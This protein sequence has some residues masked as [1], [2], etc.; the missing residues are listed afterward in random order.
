MGEVY[1]AADELLGS[2][3]ALKVIRADVETDDPHATERFKREILLARKV[4][5]PNVCRILDVGDH[6]GRLFLTMEYLRGQTLAY[7]L[8]GGQKLSLAEARRLVEQLA[9]GLGAAHDQG[10]VHR[11]F[12][13]ANV[14]LVESTNSL[15]RAVITD[16]GV[17][18]GV[19]LP[20]A[21]LTGK[22]DL[23]GTPAYMAPE[24]LEGSN[25][26]GRA[27]VYALGCVLYEMVTG[28]RPFE[29]ETALQAVIARVKRGPP[30]PR[31][32]APELDRRWEEAILRCLKLE[33]EARFVDIR[34]VPRALDGVRTRNPRAWR[35]RALV[36]LAITFGIAAAALAIVASVAPGPRRDNPTPAAAATTGGSLDAAPALASPAATR[37]SVLLSGFENLSGHAEHAWVA[38]A[39]V[40]TLTTDLA[41]TGA[42]RVVSG[43]RVRRARDELGLAGGS[44]DPAALARLREHLGCERV[45]TGGYLV[46]GGGRLR[47]DLQ[48]L[49]ARGEPVLATRAE[50]TE[51]GLLDVIATAGE[52]LR[53]ALGVAPIGQADRDAVRAAN[54]AQPEAM[55]AY[56]EGVAL[57]QA[58][59]CAEAEAKLR[60]AIELDPT[61]ARA[62]SVLSESLYC[63]GRPEEAAAAARR[64]VE[65]G[66]ALPRE[67]RL[68]FEGRAAE[69]GGDMP[70]ALEAFGALFSFYPDE[71]EYG[72]RVARLSGLLGRYDLAR[73]TFA[74]LRRLRPPQGQDPRID[75]REAELLDATAG[76]AASAAERVVKASAARGQR[77]LEAEGHARAVFPLLELGRPAEALA[78]AEAMGRI[79]AELHDDDGVALEALAKASVRR[80]QGDLIEA[81]ALADRALATWR[82]Q[83]ARRRM[84]LA[85]WRFAELA[86]DMGDLAEARKTLEEGI[87]TATSF[88]P[89]MVPILTALLGETLARQGLADEA[90]K[91]LDE[92]L[93]AG[94]LGA[95][96]RAVAIALEGR[97]QLERGAH[98]LAAAE[99]SLRNAAAAWNRLGAAAHEAAAQAE[100]AWVQSAG[101]HAA[102]AE[103]TAKKALEVGRALGAMKVELYARF[104]LKDPAAAEEL[105]TRGYAPIIDK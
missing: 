28:H 46:L 54:T 45:V 39:L 75:M 16:F 92:V 85:A 71:L 53:A 105:K 84:P 14:I 4:T 96:E 41:A 63:R 101:G 98:Q 13:P 90:R 40:E 5:H 82:A 7:H 42:L 95:S 36:A 25:V 65:L 37:T 38:T 57:A 70:R 73:Q 77:A 62:Y 67:E 88:A 68:M 33:R 3:V 15:P 66:A 49:D 79:F 44:L 55:R 20:D 23:L 29:G 6:E 104:V 58:L 60:R 32:H 59:S 76:D 21:G 89:A 30:S 78:H 43:E 86:L 22:G 8:R 12:K 31:T 81:R 83:H 17:A 69:Y 91:R 74:A 11:D 51:D 93:V 52:R 24:Q 35:R 103:A 10:V 27:D 87:D 72:I 19:D 18:R 61:Y 34:D 50:G 26:D 47:L 48:L 9:A 97:A 99:T 94:R 2:E 64:A 80:H 1:L 102:D 100:L 56:A